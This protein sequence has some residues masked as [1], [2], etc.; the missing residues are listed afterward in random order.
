MISIPYKHSKASMYVILPDS[1]DLYNIQG[2]AAGLS[3]YDVQELI[4]SSRHASV[5]LIMPKMKLSQ[6]FSIGKFL[7]LFEKQIDSGSEKKMFDS[8]PHQ[9]KMKESESTRCNDCK[10]P[11]YCQAYCNV[12][13]QS[14]DDKKVPEDIG[15]TFKMKGASFDDRFQVDDIIHHVFVEVSEIGTVGAAVS[16]TIIDYFGEFK[17][18]KMDR[19]FLF[20][21]QHDIT[22]S[23]LFWGTIVDPTNGDA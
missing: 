3:V 12:S 13:F 11:Q 23:P 22:G 14:G 5:T 17:D 4:S 9:N 7:S 15:Y 16:S 1:G 19:P 2:F 10:Y 20:F 18:F 8:D 21:I 6:T